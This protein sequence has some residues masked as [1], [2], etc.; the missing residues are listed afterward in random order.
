MC[1]GAPG[2]SQRPATSD[3]RGY[4][5]CFG[6]RASGLSGSSTNLS[7]VMT[8]VRPLPFRAQST[9]AQDVEVEMVDGLAAI[10]AAVEGQPIPAL[11][12]PLSVR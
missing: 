4:D 2:A 6:G 9:A 11:A 12:D 3:E 5:Q 10:V 7:I 1:G 8:S